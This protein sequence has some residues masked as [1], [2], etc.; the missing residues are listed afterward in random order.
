VQYDVNDTFDR[1]GFHYKIL[2]KSEREDCPGSYIYL[3]SMKE[4][5]SDRIYAHMAVEDGFFEQ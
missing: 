5:G 4:I 1:Y 2:A 3:V